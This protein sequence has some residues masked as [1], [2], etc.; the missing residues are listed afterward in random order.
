MPEKHPAR[1][2]NLTGCFSG[3][4]Y[5]LMLEYSVDNN[6]DPNLLF[7]NSN[8]LVKWMCQKCSMPWQPTIALR[9]LGE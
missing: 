5:D 6:K 1:L 7:L 2:Q 4:M 8:K 9:A 3:K